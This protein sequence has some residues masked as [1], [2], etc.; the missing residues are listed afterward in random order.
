MLITILAIAALIFAG[1]RLRRAFPRLWR[2]IVLSSAALDILTMS[3]TLGACA[4]APTSG[5]WT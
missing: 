3:N 4:S 1:C 5:A 2:I